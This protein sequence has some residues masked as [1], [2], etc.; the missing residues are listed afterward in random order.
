M[1]G[2]RLKR[3]RKV[4]QGSV[5]SNEKLQKVTRN[6]LNES[7]QDMGGNLSLESLSRIETKSQEE[8]V[9]SFKQNKSAIRKP[10][11][12]GSIQ[13][14][15]IGAYSI[16]TTDLDKKTITAYKSNAAVLAAKPAPNRP[17][18]QIR[19]NLSSLQ[20]YDKQGQS[21]GKNGS[22]A[23]MSAE[24]PYSTNMQQQT[25]LSLAA[26]NGTVAAQKLNSKSIKKPPGREVSYT[27]VREILAKSRQE[28][29]NSLALKQPLTD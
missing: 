11:R 3:P 23:Y 18:Q 8:E 10:P 9:T 16:I 17:K 1:I 7:Q 28:A 26:S 29:A 15:S 27:S 21:T 25:Q 13:H 2:P 5:N 20:R 19:R 4:L 14:E 22:V 6:S 24:E 12:P